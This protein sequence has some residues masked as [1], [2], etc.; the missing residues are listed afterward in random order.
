MCVCVCVCVNMYSRMAGILVVGVNNNR[1][2]ITINPLRN[3][4]DITILMRAN[5]VTLLEYECV[6]LEDNYQLQRAQEHRN[7]IYPV[8]T[9]NINTVNSSLF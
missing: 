5:D 1:I 8:Q 9:R 6:T 3:I 2:I 7:T 4:D